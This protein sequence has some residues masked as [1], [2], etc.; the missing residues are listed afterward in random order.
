[1]SDLQG[2]IPDS[3]GLHYDLIAS[4]IAQPFKD[5]SILRIQELSITRKDTLRWLPRA[6]NY[7][8]HSLQN[9]NL[10]LWSAQSKTDRLL[11][12]LQDIHAF[13]EPLLRAALREQYGVE[14][15]VKATFLYLYL[16]REK[17]WYVFDIK[18]GVLTRTVSLLDAALHN[19]ALTETCEPD[20]DFISEPDVRGLFDIKP[21]KRKMSIAQFQTLCRELDIGDRYAKYLAGFLLP[22]DAVASAYV[23]HNVINSD[24]S[25]FIA[26]AHLAEMTG[27]IEHDTCAL[28]LAMLDGQRNLTL[29]GNVVQ[30][31]ELSI[32]GTALTGITLI[33]PDLE[34]T[35]GKAQVIA[36]IPQDPEHPLKEYASVN[37]FLTE[38][39]RQLRDNALISST[40]LTYRQYFSQFVDQQQRGHF[41]SGLQQRQ[42]KPSISIAPSTGEFWEQRYQKKL[43][44]ILND[45]RHIAVSTADTDRNSRWAWWDN[46]KKIVSDLFNIALMVA[47]PFVPGLGELMLAYTAYQITSDV[48]ESIVDLAEGLWIEAAEHIVGVVSDVIQLAAFAAGAQLGPL[49]RLKLSPLIEGMR[50]VRLSDDQL[51]LWNPDLAPYELPS[52]TLSTNAER[53]ALGLFKHEG[54]DILPLDNRYYAVQ[55][56]PETGGY[57]I[58]HPR[59]PEAYQPELHHNG[60]GAWNHEAENPR[61]WGVGTLMRR[62]GP[63]VQGFSD[64]QLQ[65]IRVT[66]GTAEDSL[67]RVHVDRTAMPLLLADSIERLKIQQLKTSVP[68][69]EEASDNQA[70]ELLRS[71]FTQLPRGVA[72]TLLS[73]ASATEIQRMTQQQQIPLRLKVQAREA[74]FET[75]VSHAY[76]GF[77]DDAQVV[78]DTERLVLNSLRI[79]TDLFND[80]RI[81]VRDGTYDGALRC[82][83]GGDDAST[84]RV[85]IRDS[86]GQYEVRD[87]QN[88]QQHEADDFYESVLRALPAKK[89][90]QLGYRAGQ[91]R[92]FKHWVMVK[93]ET[94]AERRVLLAEPPIR[95]IPNVETELLLRGPGLSTHAVTPEERAR[96]IYPHFSEREIT[97]FVRSLGDTA[98]AL[99][100]LKT[101]D[102]GLHGLRVMLN[103]W[104]HQQPG[105]WGPGAFSFSDHGGQHIMSRL[106]ECFERKSI[107]FGE[108]ST[109]F[110][111]GYALDLSP[112]IS[113]YNLDGWWRDLPDLRHYLDQVTTL[114]L[115]RTKFSATP[116]GLLKDFP[117]LRQL[118]ARNCR[119]THLPD[120]IGKLHYLRTLRLMGN[121]IRL[122]PA[123]AEQLRHLTHMETLRLDDNPRLGQ[124]PNVER[125]P[126][127]KVLSLSNTGATTWPE[128]LLQPS[129]KIRPRGFFLDL[130]E[131]PLASIPVVTPGSNAAFIIARTRLFES[132]LSDTN[133]ITYEN[134]R[135]SVGISPKQRYT[136][137]ATAAISQWLIADDSQWWSSAV[138]GLGTFRDEAWHA[139]MTE[140]DAKGFFSV[141][142]KLTNSADYRAGGETLK[143]LSGRVWRMIEAMDLDT[144]LRQALFQMAS[145][146]TTCADAGAQI[147]NNM[148]IKVLVSEAY[149]LSTSPEILEHKL[150]MLAKGAARLSRVDDIARADFAGRDGVPD[151]VEVYLAYETGLAG[152]LDLPWQ[153]K[154]ML[155][156]PVSGVNAEKLDVAFVTVLSMEQGDGLLN[157]MI[158]Q[159][160]WDTFLS[161]THSGVLK[162]NAEHF[163]QRMALLD[164]R[165]GDLGTPPMTDEDYDRQLNDI[166]YERQQINRTLTREALKRAEQ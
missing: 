68:T 90:R 94:P 146:P 42:F 32:L 72:E 87:G 138:S 37:E 66:S 65:R 111:E 96:D 106:L 153:S 53:D 162:R 112:E 82:S 33:T 6:S 98:Q 127:L 152:R 139:L 156:R 158:E 30:F 130:Q 21:I 93:T 50:P 128:G 48:M 24:R 160:F 116:G 150:V 103:K 154:K 55:Q 62:L 119:L 95:A 43:N 3:K 1:M 25:A 8:H 40:G 131:N 46:F 165:N 122:T 47:I 61:A 110:S 114:N 161:N 105:S 4:R 23:Q 142:T 163:D 58:K 60:F 143:Q 69:V 155:H 118:S 10:S 39:T 140:P 26:A 70:V 137:A 159:P 136:N 81:E 99:E 19:F 85:L 49:V 104:R 129:S 151:E 75:R 20:S 123:A 31:G 80:L 71:T 36:Y 109:I 113:E 124:L 28:V 16:P 17:P 134:Y 148:G 86:S 166:G 35:R 44:K 9:A 145:A 107:V 5:A 15:D 157:D 141:I 144:D 7:N 135:K 88:N 57:R 59:R 132:D 117:N 83:V 125:M 91:G 11:G 147:F 115:D 79:Y 2:R 101:V 51:R 76:E 78:P 63:G 133:R 14:D 45:A 52:T 34:Q 77:Y 73:R 18:Q 92:F 67:R 27:D 41:F 13:A 22:A 38:L 89:L 149:A 74:A 126:K 84:L 54:R 121:R 100:R 164:Q 102:R 64:A 29:K 97:N 12:E 120:N 56:N 108:R